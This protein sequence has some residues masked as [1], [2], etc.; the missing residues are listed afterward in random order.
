MGATPWEEHSVQSEDGQVVG[1]GLPT[2]TTSDSSKPLGMLHVILEKTF[3]P[4]L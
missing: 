1:A 3:L 2:A 4:L